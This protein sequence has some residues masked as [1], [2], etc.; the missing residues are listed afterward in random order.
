MRGEADAEVVRSVHHPL[1]TPPQ[2]PSPTPSHSAKLFPLSGFL[3]PLSS[4]LSLHH[5]HLPS[6]LILI[7]AVFLSF[8]NPLLLYFFTSIF[9]TN[10]VFNFPLFTPNSLFPSLFVLLLLCLI[11]A[12]SDITIEGSC[13]GGGR[14]A[15]W[16]AG[17]C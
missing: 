8:P 2:P 13:S 6:I 17:P 15:G 1:L 3:Y 10:P 11:S 16:L 7:L 4:V 12:L 9:Y 5:L 14:A